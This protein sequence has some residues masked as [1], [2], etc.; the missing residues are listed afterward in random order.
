M[1]MNGYRP[2]DK[3]AVKALICKALEQVG[4]SDSAYN[5]GIVFDDRTMNWVIYFDIPRIS[6]LQFNL[7]L[8]SHI[9]S[10]SALVE[11]I[12]DEISRRMKD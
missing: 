7:T 6:P 1:H 9:S 8:S 12:R 5:Y 10:E 11:Q 4:R 2:E 3:E